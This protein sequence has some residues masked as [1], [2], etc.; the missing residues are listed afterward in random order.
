M[1]SPLAAPLAAL[2]APVALLLTVLLAVAGSVAVPSTAHA[3]GAAAYEKSAHKKT[4]AQRTKRDLVALR[5]QK[6]VQRFADHQARRMAKQERMFHQD[7]QK[8]LDAC[9]LSAVAENVAEGYGSGKAVVKGWMGSPG[10]RANILT[11]RYRLLGVGAARDDDGRWYAAQVF[12][13]K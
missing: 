3:A 7:L 6:C 2:T 11:E 13:R 5:K 8:V 10:H 12:G 1:R 9:D 4:N